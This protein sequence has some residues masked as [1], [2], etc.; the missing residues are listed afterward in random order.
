MM[1]L[2]EFSILCWY[3]YTA[4]DAHTL[5]SY[6]VLIHCAHTLNSY[7]MLIHC[8]HTLC[9]YTILTHCTHTLSHTTIHYHTL[10]YTIIM[11]PH[12]IIHYT[13]HTIRIT[14]QAAASAHDGMG[15][16]EKGCCGKSAGPVHRYS[17]H[18]E[19]SAHSLCS[20]I[21]LLIV[22]LMG[23]VLVL[24]TGTQM[25]CSYMHGALYSYIILIHCTHTLCSYTIL[26]HHTHTS[27]NKKLYTATATA[28][29]HCHC[30]HT[31]PLYSYTV[32]CT[33]CS[34]TI[35]IYCTLINGSPVTCTMLS[36]YMHYA[37]PVT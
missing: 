25:Q 34:Y 7:T 12:T 27:C 29:I 20:Y 1:R 16:E 28:L 14:L 11:Y 17:M 3:S 21:I 9:S 33:M 24:Y 6:T 13:H 18:I 22:T 26:I 36:R 31:L 32:H 4:H 10:L 37:L 19:C 35:L 15:G 5:Y 8:A 23:R 2:M 30:A